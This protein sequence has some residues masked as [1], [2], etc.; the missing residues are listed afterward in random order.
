MLRTICFPPGTPPAALA[1]LTDAIVALNADQ[2]Y[3]SEA[4]STI[5]FVPEW[6]AG[7]QINKIVQTA[8]TVPPKR[9]SFSTTT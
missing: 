9:K 2:D 7:P 1:A 4:M 3:K 6:Q 8:L 5:G